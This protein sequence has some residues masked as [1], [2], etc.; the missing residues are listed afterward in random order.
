LNESQKVAWGDL[1]VD[2]LEDLVA[3]KMT[4]LIE[5]GA[6]RDFRDIYEVCRNKLATVA[7]CRELWS[8]RQLMAGSDADLKRAKLAVQAHLKRI[9]L[10]R[11]LEQ[12]QDAKERKSAESLRHWFSKE[13]LSAFE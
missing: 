12:I 10:Q 7:D 13:F 9:A 5:R 3:S 8:K 4:A 11:P 6:P 1:L 2:S